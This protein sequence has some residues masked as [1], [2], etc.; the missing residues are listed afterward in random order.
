MAVIQIS[1]PHLNELVGREL[2][3]EQLE[4]EGS[5]LGVL[6]ED[7]EA[8]KVDVEVEPNRPDL[9]SVEGLARALAHKYTT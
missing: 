5:M 1:H 7:T 6:F 8:D 3:V 4:A 2:S 9:L